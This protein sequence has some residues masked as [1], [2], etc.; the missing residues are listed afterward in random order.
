MR[1]VL[2]HGAW[3]GGWCWEP[4]SEILLSQGHQVTCPDLPGHGSNPYPLNK[5]TY[6]VYYESLEREIAR[7]KEPVVL[8]AHSMSGI[9]AAPL[10]D[11]HPEWFDHAFFIA[12]YIA[13]NNRSLLDLALSGGPSEIP[14]ILREQK[15][16]LTQQL[17][18]QKVK[19]ALYFDCSSEIANWATLQLQ[20]QPLK[21][22]TT[23]I[24]WIDSG[25]TRHKR[26]YILCE[27]DRDVHPITQHSV[28]EHYPCNVISMQSGHFPFL[29]HPNQLTHT[30]L[31]F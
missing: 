15:D 4:L 19:D 2:V 14:K 11:K 3:Q 16:K 20:P 7:Y 26:T 18:L 28:L 22:L 31:H 17:D 10:L 9:L 12:A 5:I 25:K 8:V 13:Q 27:N 29:S 24:N 6:A 1:Y 21:P 30:L 23:P